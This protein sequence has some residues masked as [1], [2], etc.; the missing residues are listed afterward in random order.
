MKKLFFAL[1]ASVALFA[2]CEDV[3]IPAT[4]E[5][6]EE[7]LAYFEH[8]IS[9]LATQEEGGLSVDVSFTAALDWSVS[10]ADADGNAVTWLTVRPD[11]G[12]AGDATVKVS[13]TDNTAKTVRTATVTVSCG[14]FSQSIT[15]TQAAAAESGVVTEGDT[16]VKG[17]SDYCFEIPDTR[18]CYV[19]LLAILPL[20]LLSYYVAIAKGRNVDQPR[21]LAKSV[22]VE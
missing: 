16:I 8:G 1:M 2:A 21:N 20:Q 5:I 17:L 10:I 9:F 22:T 13:A 15:V 6:P 19:P 3:E 14:G 7:S 4:L 11:H 18:D 12:S